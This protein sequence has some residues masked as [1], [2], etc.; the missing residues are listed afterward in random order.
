[1]LRL[2]Q[3]G[4]AYVH[5][6]GLTIDRP[7]GTPFYVL[8]HYRTPAEVYLNGAWQNAQKH[9]I[10][11]PP[12]TPQLY[13]SSAVP[14]SNDWVHFADD[15]SGQFVQSLG[16]TPGVL[17]P[18]VNAA[19]VSRRVQNLRELLPEDIRW[20]E[21]MADAELRALLYHLS[22]SLAG[23]APQHNY[24]HYMP[25]LNTI[26]SK[27]Y[28]LP[29]ADARV[30]G[31]AMQAGLSSSYFQM[32]YKQCFGVTVGEDIINSR[33]ERACYLLK[34]SAHSISEVGKLSGY[35]C[36]EHFIRQFKKVMGCTP[37]RYRRM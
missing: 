29:T 1:M 33:I 22:A 20:R 21:E 15:D 18:C 37:G 13:R 12:G 34:N 30:D 32:V 10:L 23:Q 17:H 26:R 35:G 28:S 36:D 8:V 14:F 5:P 9:F 16:I 24:V 11:F 2:Q 7:N 25:S 31:L 19:M 3:C 6:L 4:Y 27:L